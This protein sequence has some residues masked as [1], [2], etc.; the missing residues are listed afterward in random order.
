MNSDRFFPSLSA[1][2][3]IRARLSLSARRLIVTPRPARSVV[4]VFG[5]AFL[6]Y[7][8]SLYRIVCTMST[9]NPT[10][11]HPAHGTDVRSKIGCRTLHDFCEGCG[12]FFHAQPS[13]CEER[14]GRML[15]L[16][17]YTSIDPSK[18]M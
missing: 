3:S 7:I 13:A 16:P 15:P 1:A 12:F 10:R 2:R 18:R 4:S 9:H 14:M 8:Q 5:I 17:T 11:R 6:L